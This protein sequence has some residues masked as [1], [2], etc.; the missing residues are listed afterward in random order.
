[1]KKNKRITLVFLAV[2]VAIA[3]SYMMTPDQTLAKSKAKPGTVNYKKIKQTGKDTDLIAFKWVRPKNAKRYKIA[4][5]AEGVKK[6]KYENEYNQSKRPSTFIDG[7]EVDKKYQVKIRAYNGKK[8]GKWSKIVIM[9]T[10]PYKKPNYNYDV[11]FFNQPY[12]ERSCGLFIETNNPDPDN[13]FIEYFNAK[14]KQVGSTR[15]LDDYYDLP[16]TDEEREKKVIPER[17]T[18]PG[19]YVQDMGINEAGEIT[20]KITEIEPGHTL[21]EAEDGLYE[22]G[23]VIVGK[24]TVFDYNTERTKWMKKIISDVTTENMT[25]K[26]KME[27][28][29]G[30]LRETTTYYKTHAYGEDDW[31]YLNLIEY[32][33]VP[34]WISGEWDSLDSPTALEDIGELIGYPVHNMFYDYSRGTPEWTK[35]HASVKSLTDGSM[36]SFCSPYNSNFFEDIH[37]RDDCEKVNCQTYDRFITCH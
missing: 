25:P 9:K 4:Y 2:V 31:D 10:K 33:G 26:E 5:R 6:W 32:A 21:G 11:K 1:M 3:F 20:V 34:Q 27:A 14:G 12:S 16:L 15:L 36:Y 35:Y 29:T 24:V 30:Y 23:V 18:V 7:L 17:Y 22:P 19:G 13:F 28:I 37:T 8:A